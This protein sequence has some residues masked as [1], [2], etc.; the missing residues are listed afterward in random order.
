LFRWHGEGRRAELSVANLSQTAATIDED[1]D[2]DKSEGEDKDDK[3]WEAND[4]EDND[5]KSNSRIEFKPRRELMNMKKFY[6][7]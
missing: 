1:E 2:E 3:K 4:C 5:A 7:S 6:S